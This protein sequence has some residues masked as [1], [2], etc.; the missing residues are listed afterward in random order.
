[1]LSGITF[2]FKETDA[3]FDA[4]PRHRLFHSVHTGLRQ[5]LG[6]VDAPRPKLAITVDHLVHIHSTLNASSFIDARNWCMAVFAFFGL[7]RVSEYTGGRLRWRDVCVTDTAVYLTIPYSKADLSPATV[8]LSAR[9]DM[10]CPVKAYLWYR[11]FFAATPSS[12]SAFFVVEPSSSSAVLKT[13]FQTALKTWVRSVLHLDPA[14][15][16]SHSLRRGGATALMEAGVSEVLIA[17]HGRWHSLAY[18]LYLEFS[19]SRMLMPTSLLAKYRH[20]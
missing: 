18:R 6:L 14:A 5:L 15:Y 3:S 4:L 13:S 7:L 10:L 20:F 8:A 16:A 19:G 1:M 17:S 12:D 2:W 9:P 11:S